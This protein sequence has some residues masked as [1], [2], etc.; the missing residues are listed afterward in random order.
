MT[1]DNLSASSQAQD[2]GTCVQ[3]VKSE[4]GKTANTDNLDIAHD[5]GVISG[6]RMLLSLALTYIA[7]R[8]EPH[9]T[10]KS[11]CPLSVIMD[12]CNWV[13]HTSMFIDLRTEAA[14]VT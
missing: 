10:Q 12:Q 9:A 8:Y 6:S 3:K 11:Y 2:W 4:G 14:R 7:S 5:F 1:L 13:M